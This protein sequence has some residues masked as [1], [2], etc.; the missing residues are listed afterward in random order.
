VIVDNCP[1]CGQALATSP[2]EE[3]AAI[4]PSTLHD[5]IPVRCRAPRGDA[6]HPTHWHPSIWPGTPDLYWEDR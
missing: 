2:E 5:V 6:P 1:T 3:C 4:L